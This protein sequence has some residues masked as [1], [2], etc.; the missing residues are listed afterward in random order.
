MK[1]RTQFI[2][3]ML[4]FG[5]I[6]VILAA[7]AVIV[8]Q[9]AQ[10]ADEQE[11]IASSIAQ[12]AGELSY[13]AN[14]YLIY[15]ESQQLSRWQSNFASF[16]SQVARLNVDKPGQRALFRNI[17]ANS[18][19]LKE[20]FDGVVSAVRNSSRTQNAASDLAFFQVSWSRISVQSQGLVSDASRLSK[21]L[22]QQTNQ[23]RETR[24]I[25][26]LLHGGPVWSVSL[27]QLYADLP[28][29]P[30]IV[31]DTPSSYCCR[32]LWYSRFCYRGKKE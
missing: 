24:T 7:S 30:E 17:Q 13:L 11:K 9:L 19:R 2:I 12:G 23:L 28:P 18:L 6:L 15:R 1:I 32:W 29:H 16:S 26:N 31:S 22:R 25:L 10:K 14:D 5:I 4:L 3:T 8:N 27:G 21:L 20:V